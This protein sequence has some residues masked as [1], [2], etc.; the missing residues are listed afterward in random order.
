MKKGIIYFFICL[1][2]C[3]SCN[4]SETPINNEIKLKEY[5]SEEIYNKYQNSVVLI[6]HSFVYKI[7]I[8]GK[9]FFFRNFDS[10]TGEISD[11]ISYEEAVEN[12]NTNW[13]TG[14]FID[15]NGSILTNRH[16]VDVRPNETEQKLILKAFQQKFENYFENMLAIHQNSISEYV[17]KMNYY[18]SGYI[19][20]SSY[21]LDSMKFNLEKDE[22]LLNNFRNYLDNFE[23]MNNYVTKTSLEF[24]IFVNNQKTNSFKDYI[25]YK[26]K[27]ISNDPNVDLALLIPDNISDLQK[28]NFSCA[29]M[30]KIDSAQIKPLKISDKV[31]MIGYNHGVELA[32]T[33]SGMKPQ[34]TE[35]NISQMTDTNKLLYTI[36]ALPGSSGSPIFDKFGRVVAVNF[37]GMTGTQSFNYGIQTLR[38]KQFLLN[39]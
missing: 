6:K 25:K 27:K 14:F 32:V 15:N 29:D 26:S 34:V 35:G 17:Q 11:F 38:I 5:R 16:V 36:P 18:N 4:K 31:I 20:N 12:P 1:I 3:S 7:S 33:D 37:A 28:I 19:Y 22:E 30:S 24:G 23:N 39:Q 2:L 10:L 21:E 9:D 13:G 8:D